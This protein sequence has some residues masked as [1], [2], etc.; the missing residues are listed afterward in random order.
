MRCSKATSAIGMKLDVG[1]RIRKNQAPRNPSQERRTFPT[2][3]RAAA[4]PPGG[5]GGSPGAR[6][7]DRPAQVVQA[8]RVRPER[9]AE[10]VEDDARLGSGHIAGGDA[11][12]RNPAAPV[13]RAES[14]LHGHARIEPG[15]PPA[16]RTAPS[17]GGAARRDEPARNTRS[18]SRTTTG[19]VTMTS[20]VPMPR[21]QADD[22]GGV[23]GPP[24]GTRG[25]AP[26][27]GVQGQQVEQA[28]QR[29]A[30][31]GRRR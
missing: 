25:D 13:V 9:Q 2:R 12:E 14:P 10:V 19:A 21:A 17:G 27:H 20:L 31:A 15:R 6:T 29:L 23:P 18:Y 8:E 22:R 7:G 26:D 1:A 4:P 3:S 28:H 11:L 30:R 24:P 5:P 16:P